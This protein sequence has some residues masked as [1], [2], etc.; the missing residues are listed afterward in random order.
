MLD[1]LEE[2]FEQMGVSVSRQGRFLKT[3]ELPDTI[4]TYWNLGSKIKQI[5]DNDYFAIEWEWAVFLYMQD[6][7]QIYTKM[8]EFITMAMEKGFYPDGM[9]SDVPSDEQNYVARYV[10]LKYI[11]NK[12]LSEGKENGGE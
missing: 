12:D 1:I 7:S 11:E 5:Y 4:F 2:I 3:G 8:S 9:G 10:K 6:E